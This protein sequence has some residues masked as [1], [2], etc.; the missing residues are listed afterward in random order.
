MILISTLNEDTIT[1][2]ASGPSIS[3]PLSINCICSVEELKTWKKMRGEQDPKSWV[4]WKGTES[5]LFFPLSRQKHLRVGERGSRGCWNS[6]P[7]YPPLHM[8]KDLFIFHSVSQDYALIHYS[9][10]NFR[11]MG[12]TSNFP[13]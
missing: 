10:K 12:M 3:C 13:S 1:E 11:E 6:F 8:I 7:V 2:S 4:L 5:E 9:A